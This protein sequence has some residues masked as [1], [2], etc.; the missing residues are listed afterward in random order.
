MVGPRRGQLSPAAVAAS[1]LGAS[2]SVRRERLRLV[3]GA[4]LDDVDAA[5]MRAVL[6]GGAGYR[7]EPLPGVGADPREDHGG[8]LLAGGGSEDRC[9]LASVSAGRRRS[10]FCMGG[11]SATDGPLLRVLPAGS[12]EGLVDGGEELLEAAEGRLGELGQESV[13]LAEQCVSGAS[14]FVE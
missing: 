4:V 11:P 10:S 6:R 7:G 5:R 13:P 1:Q 12:G 9:W 3:G 14:V 8:E 2:A